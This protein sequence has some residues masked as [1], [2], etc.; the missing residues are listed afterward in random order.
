MVF[1]CISLQIYLNNILSFTVRVPPASH[2]G[3]SRK[4]RLH[5]AR[6]QPMEAATNSRDESR[7]RALILMS[8]K[9]KG[10]ITSCTSQPKHFCKV[11]FDGSILQRFAKNTLKQYGIMARVLSFSFWVTY[12]DVEMHAAIS[13][14]GSRSHARF[15][16]FWRSSRSL[17]LSVLF[18]GIRCLSWYVL[19]YLS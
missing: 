14:I 19:V 3:V 5:C 17:E 11:W 13:T 12:M 16:H 7:G 4:D 2:K 18:G 15:R 1:L 10:K 8:W 9:A 6:P